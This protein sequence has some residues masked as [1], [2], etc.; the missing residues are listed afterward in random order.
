MSLVAVASNVH[1]YPAEI[2]TQGM[3]ITNILL[4]IFML[5][6]LLISD[7]RYWN[8]WVSS[9]LDICIYPLLITFIASMFFKVVQIIR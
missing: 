9:T 3:E 8:K 2:I 4:I 5:I 6:A 1:S 7:S